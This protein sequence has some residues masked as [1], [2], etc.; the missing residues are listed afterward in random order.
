MRGKLYEEVMKKIM[1]KSQRYAKLKSRTALGSDE[2]DAKIVITD[3][4]RTP[5]G[6]DITLPMTPE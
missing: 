3:V 2:G 5:E 4:N 1:R 6:K